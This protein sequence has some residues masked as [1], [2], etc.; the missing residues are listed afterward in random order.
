M[1]DLIGLLSLY[2]K[3]PKKF[4][5]EVK[6]ATDKAL[7]SEE[8]VK[9]AIEALDRHE[10]D[11]ESGALRSVRT[12]ADLFSVIKLGRH[13]I[14]KEVFR[15]WNGGKNGKI[16]SK[17]AVKGVLIKEEAVYVETQAN[18]SA[19]ALEPVVRKLNLSDLNITWFLTEEACK[20]AIDRM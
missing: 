4:D 15:V 14:G 9:M 17:V 1:K 11:L 19:E 7:S 13:L 20:K 3:N 6:K 8:V 2:N 12:V 18:Y 10:E 5:K 16:C